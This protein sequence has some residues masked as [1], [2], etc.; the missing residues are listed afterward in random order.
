MNTAGENMAGDDVTITEITDLIGWI[1]RL[2][3]AGP[4]AT[5]PAELTAFHATKADL[6][7][8]ITTEQLTPTRTSDKDTR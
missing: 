7:A 3:E 4:G 8:R 6:L 2:S 1:R 5:S